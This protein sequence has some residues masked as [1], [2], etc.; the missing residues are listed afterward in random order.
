MAATANS[1]LASASPRTVYRPDE[2]S[3]NSSAPR[4]STLPL[5]AT[6][7]SSETSASSSPAGASS[8]ATCSDPGWIVHA[9]GARSGAGNVDSTVDSTVDSD[10]DAGDGDV[11]LAA[12]VCGV[13]GVTVDELVS[14][15]P[16]HAAATRPAAT[17]RT[18]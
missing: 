8:T 14:S 16:E 13:A 9:A 1:A 10:V 17:T 18:S 15:S 2:M 12:S 4:S 11:V 7:P 3:R 5:A 6:L